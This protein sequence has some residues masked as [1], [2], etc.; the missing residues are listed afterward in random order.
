MECKWTDLDNAYKNY[1]KRVHKQ[2]VQKLKEKIVE[3][4]DDNIFS[5]ALSDTQIQ[6]I[7]AN[8]RIRSY[9]NNCRNNFQPVGI[10]LGS[11]SK[12]WWLDRL[13]PTEKKIFL[14]AYEKQ[15][16]IEEISKVEKLDFMKTKKYFNQSIDK[17][18]QSL[19]EKT[20]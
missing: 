5:P 2:Y 14:L 11:K 8:E 13:D 17:I 20:E 12:S 9:I 7:L 18:I 3:Q 4:N 10:S 6:T 19:D 1:L 15:K 16:S